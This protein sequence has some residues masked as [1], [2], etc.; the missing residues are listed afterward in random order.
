MTWLQ[1]RVH[2]HPKKKKKKELL[3]KCLA[4]GPSIKMFNVF[5]KPV[6]LDLIEASFQG[7]VG[8]E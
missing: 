3:K 8:L 7:L 1:S 2:W 5:L 6:V 4:K